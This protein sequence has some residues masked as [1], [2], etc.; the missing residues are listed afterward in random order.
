[1][2]NTIPLNMEP[3][4]YILALD[5]DTRNIMIFAKASPNLMNLVPEL[6]IDQSPP[7][8]TKPQTQAAKSHDLQL[9]P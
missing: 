5:S 4:A 2:S 1:M 3:T 6:T 8:T 9:V 7:R